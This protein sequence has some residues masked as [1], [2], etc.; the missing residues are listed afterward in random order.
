MALGR[1]LKQP[2]R[3]V[4]SKGTNEIA[5]KLRPVKTSR[6]N[7]YVPPTQGNVWDSQVL[8][9]AIS[10]GVLNIDVDELV[11]GLENEGYVVP[12]HNIV[13][14][15]LKEYDAQFITAILQ[16]ASLLGIGTYNEGDGDIYV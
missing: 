15:A 14:E 4:W 7:Y 9:G 16:G 13:I 6:K 5:I 8:A 2:I 3:D 10:E 11:E 12:K 1:T